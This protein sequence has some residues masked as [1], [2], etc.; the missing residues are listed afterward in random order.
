MQSPWHQ[1][2]NNAITK[3][4][5]LQAFRST[6]LPDQ[7]YSNCYA[8]DLALTQQGHVELDT[9]GIKLPGQ[10]RKNHVWDGLRPIW[11]FAF[12][13]SANER[14]TGNRSYMNQANREYLAVQLQKALPGSE[15]FLT[16]AEPAATAAGLLVDMLDFSGIKHK[17]SSGMLMLKLA[18]VLVGVAAATK[19]YRNFYPDIPA[20]YLEPIR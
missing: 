10:W 13:F 5:S 11:S 17:T 14:L 4:T 9:L 7:S 19:H 2:A 3:S 8:I 15:R 12:C 6:N 1:L 20:D 16:T 18:P